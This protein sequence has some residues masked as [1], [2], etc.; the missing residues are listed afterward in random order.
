[1][2][3]KFI[4]NENGDIIGCNV[5]TSDNEKE[6]SEEKFKII[7]NE[8]MELRKRERFEKLETDYQKFGSIISAISDSLKFAI[9][10]F[11]NTYIKNR[12][13]DSR[14]ISNNVT[15]EN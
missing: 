9:Q 1:M 6:L 11:S 13:V 10:E 15:E 7:I 12:E 14:K 3:I 4:F 2:E 8:F 5:N